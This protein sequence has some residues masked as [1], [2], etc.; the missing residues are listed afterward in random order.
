MLVKEA[1]S[2]ERTGDIKKSVGIGLEETIKKWF[3]ESY[4]MEP[5]DYELI[6]D[7]MKDDEL[8]METKINWST[9]LIG[10][11]YEVSE[12]VWE[13]LMGNS[14]N[15]LE[16]VPNGWTMENDLSLRKENDHFIV[17]FEEYSQWSTV[18]RAGNNSITI[19]NITKI[20][21]GDSFDLFESYEEQDIYNVI[22]YFKRNLEK[23][24]AWPYIVDIYNSLSN[25]SPV[26]YTDGEAEGD[27][28]EILTEI[29]EDEKYETL[30][31]IISD[32]CNDTDASARESEAFK[33]IL[34]EITE[35]FEIGKPTYYRNTSFYWAPISL[36]G[37][38]KIM[39][40][41]SLGDQKLDYFPS[42]DDYYADCWDIDFFNEIL[43]ERIESERWGVI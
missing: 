4:D 33:H 42:R 12:E 3:Q 8:D 38:S 21:D 10:A 17:I 13:E 39:D 34:K 41:Y 40:C 25:D 15:P 36:D 7:I 31:Y 5:K 1:I 24:P 32:V 28:E 26:K 30:K 23:I 14:V 20:L 9:Y 37:A 35:H 29:W 2:F 19:E 11:G 16:Y 43:V 6:P 22:H 18:I 27:P